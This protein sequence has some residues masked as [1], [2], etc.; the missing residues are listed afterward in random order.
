[1][2]WA[3]EAEELLHQYVQRADVEWILPYR[4]R[5]NLIAAPRGAQVT[6]FYAVLRQRQA[7]LRHVMEALRA[8]ITRWTSTPGEL[9]VLDTNVFLHAP[10][11][12]ADIDL[13]AL[14]NQADHVSPLRPDSPL[15]VIVPM[16]VLDELD[17]LKL[18]NNSR[19]RWR[20]RHALH[21][22][23]EAFGTAMKG[24]LRDR[25]IVEA[26]VDPPAHVRCQSL[27]MR[28]SSAPRRSWPLPV[29]R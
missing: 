11:K 12:F 7:A 13:I 15:H 23:D 20:A 17:N 5:E 4:A 25:V 26:V 1:M 19:T 3:T 8:E 9:L 21:V 16:V 10:D 6:L 18:H 27:T 22:L 14:I 24:R 28:S 2:H 29:G